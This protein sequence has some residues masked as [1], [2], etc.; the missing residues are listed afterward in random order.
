MP[1][2]S[3][4]VPREQFIPVAIREVIRHAIAPGN[5]VPA[6]LS[7]QIEPGFFVV[8]R[9]ENPHTIDDAVFL[10]MYLVY[11][12]HLRRGCRIILDVVVELVPVDVAKIPSFA[13]L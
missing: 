13:D 2:S 6:I 7:R 4:R 9:Y 12:Y 8:R 3:G 10:E 1:A 5:I 11:H